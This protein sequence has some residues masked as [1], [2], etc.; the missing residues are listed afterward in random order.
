MKK[1]IQF[2]DYKNS[3]LS[4]SA[5]ILNA[6]H[7]HSEYSSLKVIDTYMQHHYKNIVFL[8]LDCMGTNVLEHHLEEDSFLRRNKKTNVTTVFPSTTVAATT[9]FHSGQSP[10]EHG[11]I[12]WMPYFKEYNAIIEIFTG[13]EFYTRKKLPIPDLG[14]TIL[15]YETM[16]TTITNTNK[17]VAY[18]KVFPSFVPNGAKTIEE[19]CQNIVNACKNNYDYNLISA[20][21]DEPDHTIHHHGVYAEETKQVL[22]HIDKTIEHMVSELEDTLFIISADH[23]AV[24]IEEVYLNQYPELVECLSMPPSIETRCVTFFIKEG[25]E[26]YF[27]QKFKEIFQEDFLLFTKEEFLETGLLGN[28]K[29]H[30]KIEEYLG[31]YI[32][33]SQSEKAIRYTCTGKEFDRLLADHAG[34]TKEEMEVPVI[35]AEGGKE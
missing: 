7:C 26:L 3:I 9:A 13:K 5:S 19:L 17:N 25:K 18:H 35:I 33:I 6:F 27:K 1:E 24:D 12:G 4:I 8:I 2:P 31:T 11:W 20:Y 21:W 10:L 23:G 30:K 15:S 34:I 29:R 32:A 16:Y 28:G 14:E 22:Q